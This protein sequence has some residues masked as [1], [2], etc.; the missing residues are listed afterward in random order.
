MR[1]KSSI[2]FIL[3]LALL[4]C[5]ACEEPV[6]QSKFE[7]TTKLWPAADS[8]GEKV[9]YINEYGE[10]V[11][12]AQYQKAYFFSCGMAK[13]ITFDKQIQFI[14]KQGKVVYTLPEYTGC[15]DYFYNGYIRYYQYNMYGRIPQCG[16]FDKNFKDVIPFGFLEV[17]NM[18]KEG[19][20]ATGVGYFN[21]NGERVLTFNA[22]T[23]DIYNGTIYTYGDFCDGV[24]VVN[25]M[26]MNDGVSHG[27]V[28]AINTSGEWI[29]DT[30]YIQL[31]SLG[32]GLL[33]YMDS[34]A[35]WGLIDTHNNIVTEPKY[36]D[37]GVFED[38][39]LLAVGCQYGQWGYVDHTGTMK[40]EPRFRYCEPFHEGVAWV[41]DENYF[42]SLIDT[43]GNVLINLDRGVY[44]T[45][46]FHNG[47]TC[48]TDYN[49]YVNK[50]ID[51]DNNVIY[52]WNAK[53]GYGFY[54]RLIPSRF[55]KNEHN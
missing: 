50:Y 33:A 28:C 1:I 9:G 16:L 2:F 36:Y 10:M 4:I 11:I 35:L 25:L 34:T 37:V 19:L 21:T 24:A 49:T 52:S 42:Y 6:S 13:V 23:F 14:D 31:R 46:D 48:I 55:P 38:N 43:N 7:D 41:A 12:P 27:R 51:K 18:S 3:C 39:D 20:V 54:P 47:M 17:G 40:I 45:M 5:S 8:T 53:E 26:C 15:D 22:D 44:P 30:V 32:G 29:I